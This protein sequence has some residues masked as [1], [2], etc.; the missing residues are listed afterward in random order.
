MLFNSYIFILLFLPLVLIGYFLLNHYGKY[1]VAML[2]LLLMSLWFY[3][4][5]NIKYLILILGSIGINYCGYYALLKNNINNSIRKII[6]I[7]MI[8]F[9]LGLLFY[10]KYFNFFIENVNTLF[11]T[12]YALRDILLPMGISFFTFQQLSFIIDSYR[13][14]VPQ[15]GLLN[16]AVYVSYFP[17]LVAGPIVRYD[18]V[19]PQLNDYNKKKIDWD[20]LS[21]GFV[22]FIL[23]LAKKL[24]IA[25]VFGKA[26][27]W[28]YGNLSIISSGEAYLIMLAYT[29]QIYFDF[30]GYCDMAI[31]IAKMMNIELPMNFNSPYKAKS[32]PEFWNRWHMTLTRF[33]TEYVYIPLGGNRKGKVRTYVN[34][35]LVFLVSGIWH[36]A[37][38]TFVLWGLVH[39]MGMVITKALDDTY[40]KISST[41]QWII[42]FAFA[43]LTWVLFRAESIQDAG[44]FLKKIFVIDSMRIS[45]DFFEVFSIKEYEF[46]AGNFFSSA[47]DG[48]R[49]VVC[50]L[51]FVVAFYLA[52]VGRNTLERV[53]NNKKSVLSAGIFSFLLIWSILSLGTISPFLYFNF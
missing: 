46:L 29:M 20:N 32:I 12:E 26:V 10:Y 34:I 28:G 31:G 8:I 13:K 38:W 14:K 17:Q 5:F 49:I 7:G 23:G 21:D 19:L 9:N 33:L 44:S 16:Y 45:A 51:F 53:S 25:D 2:Y 41:L 6:L 50:L 24:L 18:E 39:G 1:R 43:N 47:I 52:C 27:D 37:N 48:G 42:T 11:Q 22:I 4:Y 36:G 35:M 30:S 15:Y 3:S 40:R